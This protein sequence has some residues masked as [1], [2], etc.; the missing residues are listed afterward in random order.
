MKIRSITAAATIFSFACPGFS[1]AQTIYPDG[2][3]SEK[4]GLN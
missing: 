1:Q 3:N 2:K 4:K